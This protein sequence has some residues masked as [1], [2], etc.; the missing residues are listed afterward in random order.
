MNIELT[1]EQL[2]ALREILREL[3]SYGDVKVTD[4][5]RTDMNEILAIVEG[6]R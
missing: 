5:G 3:V 6:A 1:Q 2:A 4:R